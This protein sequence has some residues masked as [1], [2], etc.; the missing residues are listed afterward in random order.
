MDR[1]R[2]LVIFSGRVQGVGFRYTSNQI[3]WRF[4]V[5]G[6]VKNLPDGDVQMVV[7]GTPDELESYLNAVSSETHGRVM[8]RTIQRKSATGEFSGFEIRH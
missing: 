5:T 7:E 8:K 4:D 3:A 6:W 2:F 1:V